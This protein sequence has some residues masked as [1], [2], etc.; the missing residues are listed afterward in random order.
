MPEQNNGAVARLPDP[1]SA[2]ADLQYQLDK[3]AERFPAS[4]L[5][6]DLA[7]DAGMEVVKKLLGE[8]RHATHQLERLERKRDKLNDRFLELLRDLATGPIGLPLPAGQ[9]G[10]DPQ[11]LL[12]ELRHLRDEDFPA[13][14]RRLHAAEPKGE[15]GDYQILLVEEVFIKGCCIL[16]EY[17]VRHAQDDP[18]PRP[19]S[20]FLASLR[21][22]LAGNVNQT[23]ARETGFQMTPEE[24]AYVDRL[25]PGHCSGSA[26]CWRPGRRPGCTSP[27]P[28]SAST[29][30]ATSA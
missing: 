27:T 21:M 24:G 26:S 22:H 14:A 16:F 29:S 7:R 3:I 28:G 4:R 6:V 5:L 13:L 8:L 30:A 9:E 2:A 25:I 19:D 1:A 20:E 15:V 12:P 17:M 23:L 18:P 10:V 11:T